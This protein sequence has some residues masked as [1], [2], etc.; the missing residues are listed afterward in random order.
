MST[1]LHYCQTEMNL[2]LVDVRLSRPRDQ[3]ISKKCC[4][5]KYFK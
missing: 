4:V 1:D 2:N 3:K 5:T